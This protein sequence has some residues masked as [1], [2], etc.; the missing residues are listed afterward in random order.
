M[1]NELSLSFSVESRIA[2]IVGS[3][4]RVVFTHEFRRTQ[5]STNKLVKKIEW[6]IDRR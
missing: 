5:K 3:L 6:T 1:L 4:K 2:T